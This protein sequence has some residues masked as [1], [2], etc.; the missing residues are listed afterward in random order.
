MQLD[1]SS[2]SSI[3]AVVEALIQNVD[4]LFPEGRARASLGGS[5]QRVTGK[6]GEG[7]GK[8]HFSISRRR[9]AGGCSGSLLWGHWSGWQ[10]LPHRISSFVFTQR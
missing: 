6:G 5:Q 2:V 9:E 8:E 1:L 3:Q 7:K 10:V 4:T